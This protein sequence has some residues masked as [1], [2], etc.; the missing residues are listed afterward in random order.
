MW[1]SQRF[2]QSPI[3]QQVFS[4]ILKSCGSVH[5]SLSWQ[6]GEMN[7]ITCPLFLL[8]WGL[9]S[10]LKKKKK[11]DLVKFQ[12]QCDFF[13][14][15]LFQRDSPKRMLN[16]S[17]WPRWHSG[18]EGLRGK[19]GSEEGP[20]SSIH[21]LNFFPLY[22]FSFKRDFFSLLFSQHNNISLQRFWFF[23]KRCKSKW[24]SY[25]NWRRVMIKL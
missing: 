1:N 12:T 13:V 25:W 6:S 10:F 16:R 21:L 2:N 9:W 8:G 15:V 24:K 3:A 14:P 11:K 20:R 22:S 5:W 23:S 7:G 18:S 4:V 19:L 17:Q